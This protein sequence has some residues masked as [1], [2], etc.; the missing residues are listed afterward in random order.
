[1]GEEERDGEIED[2]G[3]ARPEEGKRG[4]GRTER[5]RSQKGEVKSEKE[6]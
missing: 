2:P 1:V 4:E 5:S 6:E 3:R